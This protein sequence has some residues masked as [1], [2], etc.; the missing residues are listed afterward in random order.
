[1]YS[2]R[3]CRHEA[4]RAPGVTAAE[5]VTFGKALT[6]NP[7]G[8]G[9]KGSPQHSHQL[10]YQ[11]HPYS[12]RH[13]LF[14]IFPIPVVDLPRNIVRYM[15]RQASMN[16]RHDSRR[17]YV[18]VIH[19]TTPCRARGYTL[20]RANLIS[21]IRQN[22]YCSVF[23]AYCDLAT[24]IYRCFWTAFPTTTHKITIERF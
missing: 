5:V 24:M 19:S 16:V 7:I 15:F 10:Q 13:S 9:W 21:K 18:Q 22:N 4:R 6:R 23:D 14:A 20:P 3:R 8:I 11:N 12:P 1:M 2:S 17:E